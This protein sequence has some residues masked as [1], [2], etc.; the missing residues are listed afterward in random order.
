MSKKECRDHLG[1]VY[2]SI[3]DMCAFYGVNPR[4]LQHRLDKGLSLKDSLE[5]PVNRNRIKTYEIEAMCKKSG[6]RDDLLY[7]RIRRYGWSAEKAAT[8]PKYRTPIVVK[9]HLGNTFNS[10]NE[11]AKYW[12]I[13]RQSYCDRIKAGM[14]IEEALT[15]PKRGESW[16]CFD[17]FG[18]E[19]ASEAS[20]CQHYHIS[21]CTYRRRISQG[22]SVRDALTMPP[23]TTNK[24]KSV[25]YNGQRYASL[26]E[27]CTAKNINI[28]TVR[29]R[30][31]RGHSIEEA[32]DNILHNTS[33]DSSIKK[34]CSI[35]NIS[36]SLV[37]SR[38]SRGHSIED[39]LSMPVYPRKKVVTDHNGKVFPSIKKMCDEYKVQYKMFNKRIERGWSLQEALTI[40]SH[41]HIGEYRVAE[42]LKRHNVTFYHDCTIKTIFK[43]LH[44]DVDWNDFLTALQEDLSERGIEWTKQ[45]IA[46]LR[47][48][49]VLY[50]NN[51]ITGVIEFDGIQ[52]QKIVEY[53]FKTLEDFMRRLNADF[54]KQ[55]LWEYMNIPMLHIRHDQIDMI[56][57]IV[58]DF[59]VHPNEYITN[60]NPFLDEYEYYAPM[61][62]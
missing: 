1:N 21:K 4:T 18:N 46:R 30:I 23:K 13:S 45:R 36:Y 34:L 38:L 22:M 19:Y 59:L 15:T 41:M 9:D 58:E 47:P 39:A 26:D 44:V 33:N 56:D 35:N 37:R 20:M 10:L 6:I 61:T 50:E 43:E 31:N 57:E 11:M 28:N 5:L 52:H 17:H 24:K 12:H 32:I 3:K 40:P 25:L 7:Q 29:Q 62:V 54:I 60:H 27:L 8:A 14:T 55:S 51:G 48:D 2:S 49:F 42:C 16:T 53:F